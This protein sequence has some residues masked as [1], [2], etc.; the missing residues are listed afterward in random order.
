MK[1]E[2]K[3][4]DFDRRETLMLIADLKRQKKLKDEI[5]G[6]IDI[7]CWFYYTTFEPICRC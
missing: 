2:L 5:T 3:K 6:I 4:L 7:V 1:L